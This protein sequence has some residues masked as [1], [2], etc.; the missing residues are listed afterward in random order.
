MTLIRLI[1]AMPDPAVSASPA[2]PL[3]PPRPPGTAAHRQHQDRTAHML[4]KVILSTNPTRPNRISKLCQSQFSLIA[5]SLP[6]SL[7]PLLQVRLI[8]RQS[9]SS[10]V[11]TAWIV[12]LL[13]G[14]VLWPC[15]GAAIRNLPLVLTNVVPCAARAVTLAAVL[16]LHKGTTSSAP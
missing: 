11:S 13:A 5:D 15:Y 10:G 12:V 14:F 16:Q 2:R 7:A 9:D 6:M 1:H 4:T 3:Q 8:L